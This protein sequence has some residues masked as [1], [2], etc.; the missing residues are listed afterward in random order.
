M[1]DTTSIISGIAAL[2][3]KQGVY[4][5]EAID[6]ELLTETLHLWMAKNNRKYLSMQSDPKMTLTDV[7]DRLM[8]IDVDVMIENLIS[9]GVALSE[10]IEYIYSTNAMLEHIRSGGEH[11]FMMVDPSTGET[12]ESDDLDNSFVFEVAGHMFGDRLPELP[13]QMDHL[14][15]IIGAIRVLTII[16]ESRNFSLVDPHKGTEEQSAKVEEL[17]NTGKKVDTRSISSRLPQLFHSDGEPRR[18][19]DIEEDDEA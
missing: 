9:V 11:A 14:N 3:G 10:N 2:A 5:H 12:V 6:D 19:V 16:K 13:M 15:K 1:I 17:F 4:P 18:Q 7:I 8:N